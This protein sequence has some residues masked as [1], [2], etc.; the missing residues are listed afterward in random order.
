MRIEKV[1]LSL[2]NRNPSVRSC[3]ALVPRRVSI[4]GALTAS[5]TSAM[6]RKPA[7]PKKK[8]VCVSSAATT[9][10]ATAGVAMR[11]PCQMA[12]LSATALI[13]ALRS[14]RCG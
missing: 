3:A 1:E 10:P 11:V 12:E 8:A 13:I 9:M 14:I 5:M 2:T 7:A 4:G 6:V